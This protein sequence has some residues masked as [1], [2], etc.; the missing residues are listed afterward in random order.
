MEH[1]M[2]NRRPRRRHHQWQLL[3]DKYNSQTELSQEQ[4]CRAEDLSVGTFRKWFYKLASESRRAQPSNQRQCAPD[5]SGFEA[6]TIRPSEQTSSDCCL[7]LPG[8]VRLHTQT[9]PSVEYL[10]NLVK[11][12]GYGH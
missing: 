11:V 8:N 4:F 9:L 1:T 12:F 7:E 3:I 6:V 10:Q 2:S 5:V